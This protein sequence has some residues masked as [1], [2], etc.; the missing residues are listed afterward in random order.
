MNENEYLRG[1]SPLP[2]PLRAEGRAKAKGRSGEHDPGSPTEGGTKAIQT[3]QRVSQT[4]QQTPDIA[5]TITICIYISNLISLLHLHTTQSGLER[6]YTIHV[7]PQTL[8]SGR[9]ASHRCLDP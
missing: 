2:V 3:R 5:I 8:L 7:H 1:I 6:L 9:V 4:D